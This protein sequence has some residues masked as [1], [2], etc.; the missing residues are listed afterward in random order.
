[1]F[2]PETG[3]SFW[4]TE[5]KKIKELSWSCLWNKMTWGKIF[6]EEQRIFVFVALKIFLKASLKFGNTSKSEI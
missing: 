3:K 1:M 5:K 4:V 2:A 6:I